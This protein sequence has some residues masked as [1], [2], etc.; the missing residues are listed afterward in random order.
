MGCNIVSRICFKRNIVYKIRK[1]EGAANF[2]SSGSKIVLRHFEPLITE[3]T[4][5]LVFDPPAALLEKLFLS[6]LSVCLFVVDFNLCYNLCNIK[7]SLHIWHTT[8]L[9]MF[10][11][12]TQSSMNV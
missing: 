5:C 7:D 4:I 3:R 12:V 8:P 9:M 1:V 6:C 11:H 10:F 2:V